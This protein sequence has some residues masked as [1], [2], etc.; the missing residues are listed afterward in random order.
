MYASQVIPLFHRIALD[1]VYLPDSFGKT[2]LVIG[3][4]DF[5]NWPEARALKG[6][7]TSAMIA[8][9]I[10]EDIIC[11]HGLFG[12]LRV[13][14]G[15]ENMGEVIRLLS[16]YDV[17]R[18]V[19]SPYNSKANGQVERGHR[20]ISDALIAM[21][22]GRGHLWY[23]HLSAVL[24]AARTTVHAPTGY[25]PFFIIYGREVVL[26]VETQFPTWR[27]LD[28]GRVKYGDTA[29][30]LALRARQIEMRE[31]DVEEA[32]HRKNRRRRE[33]QEDFDRRHNIRPEP[34]AEGD[35]VLAYDLQRIDQDKSRKTKLLYRWLGPFRVKTANT[36]KGSYIIEELDGAVVGTTYSGNR[37][38]KFVRRDRHWYSAEDIEEGPPIEVEDHP[39]ADNDVVERRAR[40]WRESVQRE[41]ERTG[42]IV[43]V[44]ALP[45]T[46]KEQYQRFDEDWI[47]EGAD[48]PSL[49]SGD[50]LAM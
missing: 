15:R 45:A 18:I 36:L 1:V 9:F 14:G 25:T 17:R 34:L 5:S 16:E 35:L 20:P 32:R 2:C 41:D 27:T 50:E 48:I 40:E 26:P 22:R 47:E 43:R 11:R 7:V 30:L 42:V 46:E 29:E 24:F 33:G 6:P 21:T 10:W 23:H 19:I 13:D 8:A 28:W 37:L 12:E 38:K 31:E 49:F 44:P 3:R 39:D 4:C